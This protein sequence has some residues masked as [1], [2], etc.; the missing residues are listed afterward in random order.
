MY[1]I[2]AATM[3]VFGFV[4]F[5]LI[6]TGSPSVFDFP[7]HGAVAD[8]ARHAVRATGGAGPAKATPRLVI[9]ARQM[10]IS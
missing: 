6:D 9:A 8:P 1:I 10:A 2:G 7:C 5:G 3:E 4:Y